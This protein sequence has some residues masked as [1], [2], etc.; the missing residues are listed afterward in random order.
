M[1]LTRP[2][3]EQQRSINDIY[4]V[5]NGVLIADKYGIL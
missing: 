4:E 5:L 3:P 1:S 2:K